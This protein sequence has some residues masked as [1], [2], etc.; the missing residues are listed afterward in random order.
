ML[1]LRSDRVSQRW[2]LQYIYR[3]NNYDNN[4]CFLF[5]EILK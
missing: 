1:A 4:N 5:G 3:H 2:H